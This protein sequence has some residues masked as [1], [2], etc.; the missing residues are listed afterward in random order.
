MVDAC[1]QLCRKNWRASGGTNPR[2]EHAFE[3]GTVLRHR[4]P[5]SE[6]H[7][8]QQGVQGRYR[9]FSLQVCIADPKTMATDHTQI[10]C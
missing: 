8:Q 10:P 6:K 7:L 2:V 3:A 5:N 9:P 1:K 4:I